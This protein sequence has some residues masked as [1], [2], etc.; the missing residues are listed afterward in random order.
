MYD[1]LLFRVLDLGGNKLLPLLH[2]ELFTGFQFTLQKLDLSG[3]TNAPTNLQELRRL[4]R[5][6]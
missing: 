3:E 5:H 1:V 6:F 2:N 4:C